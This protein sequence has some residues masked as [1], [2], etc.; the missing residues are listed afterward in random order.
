MISFNMIIII[1]MINI[2]QDPSSFSFN[3]CHIHIIQRN[4]F[5]GFP[6]ILLNLPIGVQIMLKFPRFHPQV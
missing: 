4:R 2:I 1:I 5:L 3:T 6:Y